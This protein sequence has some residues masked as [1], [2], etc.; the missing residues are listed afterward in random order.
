MPHLG[1]WPDDVVAESAA[2]VGDAPDQGVVGRCHSFPNSLDRLFSLDDL[3]RPRRQD[4][5]NIGG[6]PAQVVRCTLQKDQRTSRG[7]FSAAHL[8]PVT[9]A[10]GQHVVELDPPFWG[11]AGRLDASS[12]PDRG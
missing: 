6:R 5:Q 9:G 2:N 8:F 7:H 10:V 12:R 11:A 1:A 4:R 3:A